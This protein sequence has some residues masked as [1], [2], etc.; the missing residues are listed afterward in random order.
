MRRLSIPF[1]LAAGGL[2]AAC[3]GASHSA[4]SANSTAAASPGAATTRT[5]SKTQALALARAVNLTAADVP[6]FAVSSAQQGGT[7]RERRLEGE[8]L[9]CV[10]A[11]GPGGSLAS[12]SSKN[13]ELKRGVVDLGL[14]SEVAVAQTPAVASSEL[15]A[16]R[17]SHVRECFSR[18]LSLLFKS[19]RYGRATAGPVSI[20]SGT[21][22]APG[23]TGG[24]G[25]RVTAT[26]TDQTVRLPFYMDILGFVYGPTRVTLFSSGA[27]QPFPAEAQQRLFSL[28]LG[29]AKAHAS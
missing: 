15:A 5:L 8:M 22:P 7:A 17:S 3:G 24:F 19:Q 1:L 21:P 25:W 9:R 18:Y 28:L 16:I 26:L 23:T 29:R 12:A 13:F 20:V 4:R 6:G 27:L 2:L 10:G 11:G 14:S